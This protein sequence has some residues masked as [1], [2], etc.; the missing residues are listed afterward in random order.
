MGRESSGTLP[1]DG[2]VVAGGPGATE[3]GR[4][5]GLSEIVTGRKS[6]RELVS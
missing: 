3:G 5:M 4:H 1:G 2:W 6:S